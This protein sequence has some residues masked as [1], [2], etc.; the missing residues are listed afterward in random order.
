MTIENIFLQKVTQIG[1]AGGKL[2][3][4]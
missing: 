3:Y 1:I 4:R 2:T